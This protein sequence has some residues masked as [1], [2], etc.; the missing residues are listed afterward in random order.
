MEEGETSMTSHPPVSKVDGTLNGTLVE[1]GSIQ[2]GLLICGV[3][4][5][6]RKFSLIIIVAIS[7]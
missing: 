1:N 2:G 6:G 7:L 5:K 3:V 4:T